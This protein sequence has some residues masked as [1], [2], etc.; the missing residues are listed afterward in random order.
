MLRL[1]ASERLHPDVSK[2]IF[3]SNQNILEIEILHLFIF[4]QFDVNDHQNQSETKM[5]SKISSGVFIS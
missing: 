5:K 2:N 1:S 4:H 3:P